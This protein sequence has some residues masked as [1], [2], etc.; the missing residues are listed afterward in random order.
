MSLS[1]KLNNKILDMI[2]RHSYEM[3]YITRNLKVKCTCITHETKQADPMC[4]KCLG[5]GYKI[6]IRKIKAAAQDTKL[7]P[8]F[9]SDKFIVARNFFLNKSIDC[10]EDDIIVDNDNAYIVLEIQELLSLEGTIPYRKIS[11]V[12]KKFDTTKFMD[13][14]NNIIRTRK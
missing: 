4:P 9:R 1:T 13:N 14:F 5:T 10:K 2:E 11:G 12:K 7:P 8:T 3:Y 6:T